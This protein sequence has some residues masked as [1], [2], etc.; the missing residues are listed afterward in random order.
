M[1]IFVSPPVRTATTGRSVMEGLSLLR[2]CLPWQLVAILGFLGTSAALG[3][4][5]QWAGSKPA[6]YCSTNA[7]AAFAKLLKSSINS[8]VNPCDSFGRFVC[9]GWKRSSALSL[10]ALYYKIALET[11]MRAAKSMEVPTSHQNAKQ[12]AAALLATCDRVKNGQQDEIEVVK[13]YLAEAGILWPDRAANPNVLETMLYLDFELNWPAFLHVRPL[14]DPGRPVVA[15]EVANSFYSIQ[16]ARH[17]FAG[18]NRKSYFDTLYR[19]YSGRATSDDIAFEEVLEADVATAPLGHFLE[20][21]PW[22][23]ISDAAMYTSAADWRH[24]LGR[25]F[26]H[27]LPAGTPFSTNNVRFVTYF[28]DLWRRLGER[29]MHR[30]LSW[31]AVQYAGLS[32]NSE[33][34]RNNYGKDLKEKG[35]EFRKLCLVISYN[36][37]GDLV[38]AGFTEAL[39]F[40]RVRDDVKELVYAVRR[41]FTNRIADRPPF[42]RNVDFTARWSSVEPV[43]AVLDHKLYFDY[44]RPAPGFPDMNR[45]HYV[46]NWRKLAKAWRSRATVK[47]KLAVKDILG[48]GFFSVDWHNV[49]FV[50]SPFALSFP[51][52]DAELA[53]ALKYGG[54]GSQV[55][56]ASAIV[57]LHHYEQQARNDSDTAAYLRNA[58][59][60]VNRSLQGTAQSEGVVLAELASLE[61]LADAFRAD[62]G[63]DGAFLLGGLERYTALQ[64]FFIAWCFVRC[65]DQRN[66]GDDSVEAD[67]CSHILRNVPRVSEAFRCSAGTFLNPDTKCELF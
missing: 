13:R 37:L 64:M 56:L 7:C 22:A 33:L 44:Q 65:G 52:Y 66:V 12:Q 50:L 49:D 42:S 67:P 30:C 46:P 8:S 14:K 43:F 6:H 3:V 57:L 11:L 15:I 20:K 59:V 48:Y 9:D 31:Y 36:S 58:H 38:F 4:I 51:L 61:A 25:R 40:S 62:G 60:C 54:L 5:L 17:R 28:F 63:S 19:H 16:E 53:P 39:P 21:T 23:T 32:A 29:K 26:G 35:L 18:D 10:R 47:G 1:E 34:L 27:A 41:G 55:A 24:A 45:T 2:Q